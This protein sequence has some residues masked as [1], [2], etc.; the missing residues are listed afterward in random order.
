MTPQRGAT[1][2]GL[3]GGLVAGL[4]I[5][6]QFLARSMGD[7]PLWD[8]I[9]RGGIQYTLVTYPAGAALAGFLG[10]WGAVRWRSMPVTI[11]A[12]V[13]ASLLGAIISVAG[14][15]F[16]Y[17]HYWGPLNSWSCSFDLWLTVELP[18]MWVLLAIVT[19]LLARLARR[20][21]GRTS[22]SRRP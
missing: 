6:A 8:W 20:I 1:I 19:A 21:A 7:T 13:L 3:F 4:A 5:A 18:V 22:S 10:A 9:L 12:V 16:F 14:S 2:V 15:H 11:L 17:C